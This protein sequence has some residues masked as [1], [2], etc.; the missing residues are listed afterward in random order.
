MGEAALVLDAQQL[1]TEERIQVVVD[2]YFKDTNPEIR[3]HRAEQLR[4]RVGFNHFISTH[5]KIQDRETGAEIPFVLWPGQRAVVPNMIGSPRLMILKARQLG[6]TWMTA[7]YALW[8]A[9][10]RKN[11]L[12]VVISAKEDL[13]IEF[14]DRVKFMFDRLPDFMKAMVYKRSGTELA[15][16]EASRD[17][18]GNVVLG[19]LDSTIKSIPSTPDA[20]QSKTISLLVMDESALNRYCR[21][22]W[23]AAKP[24]LEHAGGQAI[25]ISNPTKIAPG[26]PWT[27]DLY[28]GSMRGENEF[29]RIFLNWEC[30]PGRGSGFLDAQ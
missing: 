30:V 27:R 25:I 2:K 6:L 29:K 12:V 18:M 14:L 13:A 3:E 19:G 26:W 8:R 20:G 15:F 24:T 9:N 11:E 23:S 17:A 22:I 16:G 28:K 7:A 10:F 1:L 4:C 21:E 5:C